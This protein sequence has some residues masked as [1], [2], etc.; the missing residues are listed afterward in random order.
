MGRLCVYE[1]HMC[2]L[3]SL[4]SKCSLVECAVWEVGMA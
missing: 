3:H 1:Y 4:G 2:R